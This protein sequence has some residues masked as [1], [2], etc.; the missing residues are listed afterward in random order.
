VVADALAARFEA[1]RLPLAIGAP[2]EAA[3]LGAL[4]DLPA[5]RARLGLIVSERARLQSAFEGAGWRV[6]ES[7]ANFLLARPPDAATIAMGLLAAGLVVRSYPSGPLVDC[8]RITVRAPSENDR[9]LEALDTR[10]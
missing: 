1:A 10:S 8:L 7:H 9:L 2:S 5:M 3:A 4:S 6:Y